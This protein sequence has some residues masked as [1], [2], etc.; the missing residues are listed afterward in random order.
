MT[1][2]LLISRNDI[3]QPKKIKNYITTNLSASEIENVNGN[4]V[5]SRLREMIN[6]I[7][8]EKGINDK[9]I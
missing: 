3:L 1:V 8:F 4:R 7:G 2:I 6:L 5:L 9:R